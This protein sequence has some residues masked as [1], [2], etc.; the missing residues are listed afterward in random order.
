MKDAATLLFFTKQ[1]DLLKFAQQVRVPEYTLR[2]PNTEVTAISVF[3]S[4][5]SEGLAGELG[6]GNY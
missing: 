2:V 3:F 5:G 4:A 6:G 1:S